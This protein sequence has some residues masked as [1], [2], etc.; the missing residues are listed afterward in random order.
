MYFESK[1]ETTQSLCFHKRRNVDLFRLWKNH[2]IHF[3]YTLILASCNKIKSS[4]S[5]ISNG[6]SIWITDKIN[7]EKSD[8]LNKN[9]VKIPRKCHNY[10]AQPP[11]STLHPQR[12]QKKLTEEQIM[13]TQTPHLTPTTY[14]KRI[15]VLESSVEKLFGTAV[16][17]TPLGWKGRKTSKQTTYLGANTSFTRAKPQPLF[18]CSSRLQ[19]YV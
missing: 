4:D 16:D 1:S 3:G 2:F 10:E 7:S 19:I 8:H 17:M 13:A 15:I 14:Y 11:P 5:C 12:H 18:S 9:I 6:I